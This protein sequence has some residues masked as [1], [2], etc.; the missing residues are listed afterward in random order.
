MARDHTRIHTDIWGDDDWLDLSPQAQHL[1]FVLYT[2]PPSFCGAGDWQPK[3]VAARA[4]GWTAEDV[5]TAAAELQDGLF[6]LLDLDTDEYLL[7]SWIKHDG[8]YRVQN[9]AVSIANARAALASRKLR[10]VVV[11]E[12]SKLRETEPKLESWNKDAVIKMLSQ[13]VVDP[14]SQQWPS[15]WVSSS[16]SGKASPWVSGSPPEDASPS[17]SSRATPSPAPATNSNSSTEGPRKRGPNRK[18]IPDDYMPQRSNVDKIRAEFP[19]ITDT[20]LK[21]VHEDFCLYWRGQ[22]K[23][24]AD[25]DATWLRWMRKEL[26]KHTPGRS[27]SAGGQVHKLRSYAELASEVRAEEQAQNSGVK[28]LA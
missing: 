16:A 18:R 4:R 9:M 17:D 14:E 20:V 19:E 23:P 25:W 3:K 1:Y 28:E 22:G 13:N 2:G 5:N 7:R 24:M 21:S 12:V 10:G 27:P 11:F 8:L 26:A 6:L 15:P